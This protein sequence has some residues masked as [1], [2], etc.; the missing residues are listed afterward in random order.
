[1]V[2]HYPEEGMPEPEPERPDRPS[3]YDA[4]PDVNQCKVL[5]SYLLEQRFVT[6]RFLK[7]IRS[8]S[9]DF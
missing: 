9:Y 1:M 8:Q 2:D 5:R 4:E 7:K 6:G 3:E